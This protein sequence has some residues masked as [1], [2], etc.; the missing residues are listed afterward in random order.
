MLK[1]RDRLLTGDSIILDRRTAM[2]YCAVMIVVVLTFVGVTPALA[3]DPHWLFSTSI[4]YSRGDYGTDENTTIVYVPFT[5]G[6]AWD[7]LELKLTVPYLRQ[8][9]ETV[10]VTGGGVAVRSGRQART[11]E[12]GIGDILLRGSYIILEEQQVLPEVAPYLKI[13]FP[14][15]DEDRGLGTGKFDETLG[16]DFAKT[17][18]ERWTGYLTLAY[19]FIGSPSGADL[20]DSFSWSMGAAYSVTR[21]LSVFAFLD[22]A[23]AISPHQVDPWGLRFGSEYR[24]TRV[25]KLTGSVGVGLTNGEADFSLSGGVAFRF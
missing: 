12:D 8:T 5:F 23:Q 14:T 25:M 24:L 13:K 7:R 19:T 6:A 1:P 4:N 20:R 22:G 16:A 17:F 9:S 11:T 10:T 2:R 21:P 15:A 18:L 3:E